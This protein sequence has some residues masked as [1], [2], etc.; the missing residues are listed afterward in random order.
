M[1]LKTP[2]TSFLGLAAL[3]SLPALA[4][5]SG[6][7]DDYDFAQ[8]TSV[9][10]VYTRVEVA[11]PRERCWDEQ[12]AVYPRRHSATPAILG[13]IIGGAIGNEL[14]HRKRNKQVG[15]IAGAALGASIGRDIYRHQGHHGVRY[16]T[17]R[18]CE[19]VNEYTT[20]QEISGYD[21]VYLYNGR[22]Y[23]TRTDRHPGDRMR[24]MVAVTPLP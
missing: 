3:V 24:V 5:P 20:R 21:V 7:A 10:P 17:E 6:Y 13:G 18:R 11:Q 16:V 14:G 8:V 23:T 22:E 19:V 12:V 1:N 2:L 9:T 4:G 15:A